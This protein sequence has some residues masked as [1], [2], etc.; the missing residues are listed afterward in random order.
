M[1][2]NGTLVGLETGGI[3]WHPMTL[4][5][6]YMTYTKNQSVRIIIWL[7]KPLIHIGI[8]IVVSG[9]NLYRD[10]SLYPIV[11]RPMIVWLE[12]GLDG[13]G[14]HLQFYP[15]LWELTYPRAPRYFWKS[16]S[17]P[18]GWRCYCSFLEGHFLI[19]HLKLCLTTK[20]TRNRSNIEIAPQIAYHD[21]GIL[22]ASVVFC[23]CLLRWEGVKKLWS[24]NGSHF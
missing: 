4:P 24:L 2:Q 5:D 23:L 7:T 9:C 12:D 15:P 8:V 22:R 3:F 11:S 16:C 18:Q 17:F 20:P 10:K 19:N 14:K 21:W 1:N 13:L 6:I